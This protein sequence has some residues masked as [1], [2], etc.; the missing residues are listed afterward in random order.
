[1]DSHSLLMERINRGEDMY[2]VLEQETPY[3]YKVS[4]MT[5]DSG[6]RAV[7]NYYFFDPTGKMKYSYEM[8]PLRMPEKSIHEFFLTNST[9]GKC[10]GNAACVGNEGMKK[11]VI[12][13]IDGSLK[14]EEIYNDFIDK[15]L[16]KDINKYDKFSRIWTQG[17]KSRRHRR[18]GRKSGK[19]RGTR[20]VRKTR[21]HRRR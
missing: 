7:T 21:R 13:K 4:V 5:P 12:F 17:G 11:V 3:W 6:A 9:N 8:T 20:K 10:T 14:K 16:S 15:I 1:M 18:K 19:R 2:E